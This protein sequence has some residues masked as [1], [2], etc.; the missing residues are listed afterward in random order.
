MNAGRQQSRPTPRGANKPTSGTRPSTAD[1]RV[2]VLI[3]IG[4]VGLVVVALVLGLALGGSKHGSGS[5]VVSAADTSAVVGEATAVPLAVADQVGRGDVQALPKRLT[6]AP[7]STG[8]KPEVFY[9]GAEYCPYCATERWA[10]VIALSRFGTFS[11]LRLTHS[12]SSDVYPDTPTFT[13]HGSGYSSP[14]LDFVPVET[15]TNRPNGS[16]GYVPLDTPTPEQAAL[17]HSLDPTGGIPFVDI[18]GR[19]LINGVTYS[20]SVLQGHTA[21]QVADSLAQPATAISRGAVGAANTLVAALCTLTA[22]QPAD[23]CADPA[24]QA[25]QTA[26]G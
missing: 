16:G 20:P 5:T 19:Y 13:F 8:G 11:G 4:V 22:G 3:V 12:S 1:R 15:T 18:G 25:L 2:T 6:G 21:L 7:L 10:M 9:I 24:V 26:I 14:Y 17:W 23:V